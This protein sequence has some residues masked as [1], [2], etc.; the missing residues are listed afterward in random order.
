MEKQQP[1]KFKYKLKQPSGRKD[2]Q[3]EIKLSQRYP[4]SCTFFTGP[5]QVHQISTG[6]SILLELELEDQ[7]GRY[8][9]QCARSKWGFSLFE[10]VHDTHNHC[11]YDLP[12]LMIAHRG[13]TFSSHAEAILLEAPL[14]STFFSVDWRS[15]RHEDT[16]VVDLI[17]TFNSN[18]ASFCC[19]HQLTAAIPLEIVSKD[20][21]MRRH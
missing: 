13:N 5:Q 11:K 21:R 1:W 10:S 19:N 2:V 20:G 15:P 4:A 14:S 7:E 12:E 9:P 16:K 18:P 17:V 3:T 6:A 8:Q